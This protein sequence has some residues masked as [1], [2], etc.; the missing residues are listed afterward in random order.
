[1]ANGDATSTCSFGQAG[2][3]GGAHGPDLSAARSRDTRLSME[4]LRPIPVTGPVAPR[5]AVALA[6]GPV[7]FTHVEVSTR[8][9]P[10]QIRPVAEVDPAA[11]APLIAPRAALAG[12]DLGR[13]CLMG[14]L[15]VTPDSFSDGGEA[16]D[17]VR[18]VAKA[19]AMLGQGADLIDIGGESTR[20]GAVPVS[21]EEEIA[22]VGPVVAAMRQAGVDAPISLDTRNA[23]TA[24]A[25]AC[26]I[27]ND[28]S[29]LRHDPALAQVAAD[30]GAALILMHS[31]GTPQTMQ[32]LAAGA[33]DHVVLD[34]Y[35]ALAAMRDRAE[36]AGVPRARIVLD[37]GIGFGK[38]DAQNRA[39]L[40]RIGLFHGLGCGLLLGVS[41]KGMIGRIGH[42]SDATAR[43]P[44][45]AA[46]GL[47]ALSQGIQ[48][49]RVHDIEVHAQMIR[50]WRAVSGQNDTKD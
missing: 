20:P 11:L 14:I 24:R 48:M 37:P 33:Y 47:W 25:V 34:V 38:T 42:V 1:M 12:L 9:A 17:P 31:I 16:G 39:L 40:E 36:A 45:S 8:G 35:D 19:Q 46:V 22:R 44:A 3:P 7:R 6:G 10:P 43:G 41:R 4:Y 32:D 26:P 21:A 2:C 15:N 30:R 50:L 29:G 13:P 28:V 18:A 5:G 23:A 49:L 27:L